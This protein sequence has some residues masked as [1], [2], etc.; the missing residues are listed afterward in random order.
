[1]KTKYSSSISMVLV[2]IIALVFGVIIVLMV[3][4]QAWLGVGV[5]VFTALFLG[6]MFFNTSYTLEGS[7]LHIKCGLL[8]NRTIEVAS[9]RKISKSDS[10]LASPAASFDRIS[11]AFNKFDE[12]LISPKEKHQL[13]TAL[14]A[15]NPNIAV[16]KQLL[17]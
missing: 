7:N 4:D 11:I 5:M 1:M 10:I 2:A 15:I 3:I 17:A 12:V 6:Q 13:I 14:L 8:Y 9:I 16:E